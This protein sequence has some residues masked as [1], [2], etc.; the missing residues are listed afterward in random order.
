MERAEVAVEEL[1]QALYLIADEMRGMATVGGHYAGN[2]YEAERAERIMGLAAKV[3]ALAEGERHEATT[4]LFEAEPWHRASPA[5][6]VDAAVFN[7]RGEILLV[8]RRDNAHWCMPGGLSEIGR[9]PAESALYELWEEAGLRGR[10]ERLLAVFD[11]RRWGSRAK[12]H[13][14]HFVF[15]VEC[16]DLTPSPGIE[17]IDAG[18]FAAGRLP[19]PMLR[20]H[21]MRVPKVFELRASGGVHF[22]PAR[23]EELELSGH[24]RPPPD[25]QV[26]LGIPRRRF[27][28][29]VG[30]DHVQLAMPR[31]GEEQARAFYA[32]L[33]G[34]A[35]IPK[36]E[37]LA[38]S[39][40]CWF[41]APGVQLHLGVEEPF[42]PARKAHP[43][44]LVADLE[45]LRA[46]LLGAG[47]P[48]TPDERAP[49]VRRFYVADP[50]GNRVECIQDGEGFS[51]QKG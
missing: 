14:L 24:Q 45:R 33:L 3:A 5:I 51:Q 25:G 49:G 1:R 19:E 12:A 36:P 37:P 15:L 46:A 28:P 13:L 21:A 39:G 18:F 29:L 47:A 23:A 26:A 10:A 43:A 44:L 11:G 7:P 9:T 42:A 30:L 48:V 6:G 20:G 8:Q 22:D 34:M 31:G 38:A 4:A 2:I 41:R 16:D 17:S 40:G 32:G 35:E 50:F 27:G